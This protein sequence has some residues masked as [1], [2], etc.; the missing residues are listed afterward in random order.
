M[1]L[2]YWLSSPPLSLSLKTRPQLKRCCYASL[3]WRSI[4]HLS[5]RN[6]LKMLGH[7][8]ILLLHPK[9]QYRCRS[10]GNRKG[11]PVK[12]AARSQTIQSVNKTQGRCSMRRTHDWPRAVA[13][14]RGRKKATGAALVGVAATGDQGQPREENGR[15]M[16]ILH[17]FWRL[18]HALHML[19]RKD[20]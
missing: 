8:S 12:R 4:F 3:H 14:F 9:T 17:L 7:S 19:R 6:K 15:K 10:E 2:T 1:E 18:A 13:Q 16:Q 20:E 11:Q 5:D